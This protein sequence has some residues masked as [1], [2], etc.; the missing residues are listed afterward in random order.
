ML[1]QL[2]TCVIGFLFGLHQLCPVEAQKQD[3]KYF[4]FSDW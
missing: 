1:K 4:D 2:D 3:H